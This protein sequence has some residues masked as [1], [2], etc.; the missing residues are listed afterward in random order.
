MKSLTIEEIKNLLPYVPVQHGEFRCNGSL[1]GRK[2]DF[3]VIYYYAEPTQPLDSP[4]VITVSW[5]TVQQALANG[6]AVKAS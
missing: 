5:E 1:R 3:P 2:L 6:K 4:H